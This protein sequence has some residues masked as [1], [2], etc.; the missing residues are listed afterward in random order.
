[1]KF[2]IMIFH[3]DV[4]DDL[5]EFQQLTN[6][7]LAH[8]QKAINQSN[9]VGAIENNLQDPSNP[10]A[11]LPIDPPGGGGFGVASGVDN[12]GEPVND[13]DNRYDVQSCQPNEVNLQTPGSLTFWNTKMGDK[14]RFLENTAPADN[15]ADFENAFL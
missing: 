3:T 2:R 11:D 1:M 7:K 12:D 4:N 8:I 14:I 13:G 5:Q 9:I 10:T 15:Y 6:F